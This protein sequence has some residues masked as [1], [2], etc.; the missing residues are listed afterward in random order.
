MKWGTASTKNNNSRTI[1]EVS[2]SDLKRYGI[3]STGQ[4]CESPA[5]S[6]RTS[7]L[8]VIGEGVETVAQR[9]WL[10]TAGC[11]YAQGYLFSEAIP[12]D[13]FGKLLKAGRDTA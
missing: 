6:G 12:P 2:M 8:K 4:Q 3:V 13:E 5:S 1:V 9:D 11:D 7:G 10:R